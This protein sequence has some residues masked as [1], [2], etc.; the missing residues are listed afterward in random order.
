MGLALP[1]GILIAPGHNN[2]AGYLPLPTEPH[3]AGIQYPREIYTPTT[4]YNDG[5]A[6]A[7]LDYRALDAPE[8]VLLLARAGLTTAKVANVTIRLPGRDRVTFTDYNGQAVQ[9][10]NGED[11][12]WDVLRYYDVRLLVRKLTV[13]V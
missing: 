4:V 12:R 1:R 2:V 7:E 6:F 10:K 13:V 8:Y 11:Q 3:F 5:L 9:P